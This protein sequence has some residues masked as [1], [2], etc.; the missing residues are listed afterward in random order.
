MLYKGKKLLNERLISDYNIEN[1]NEILL[2]KKGD[3]TPENV[4]LNQNSDNLNLNKNFLNNNNINNK[5]INFNEVANVW[6]KLNF[7]SLFGNV[8]WI[9]NCFQ[10]YGFGKLSETM[11]VEPQKIKEMLND[12][13]YKEIFTK[14][15]NDPSL[16]EMAFNHPVFQEKIKN[17]PF[18]KIGLQ[19]QNILLIPQYFQMAQNIIPKKN[20]NKNENYGTGISEPPGPFEN[21]NNN[22]ISQMTDFSIQIPNINNFNNI[23]GN[24]ENLGNNGI[25]TDYKEK[26]KEQLSQLKNMG[27]INEENN[28]QALKQSNGIIDDKVLDKLLQEKN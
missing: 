24:K 7:D 17:F 21:L 26:Y 20:E 4:Q 5:E 10:S 15:I 23:T 8:D 22:Q 27:F 25:N 14:V 18:L 16:I 19:N 1:N 11:G 2:V 9:D 12:P 13:L 3:P 28:I 6:R